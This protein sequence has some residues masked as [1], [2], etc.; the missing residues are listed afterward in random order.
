M[1]DILL[2]FAHKAGKY[3]LTQKSIAKTLGQKDCT[4]ESIVTE[5]DVTVSNMFA[6]FIK[7]NF[8]KL[9]Y[10][11]I[12]EEKISHLGHSVFDK[13]AQT[14]YQFVIDPIDG[15]VQFATG[16]ALYGITIG[17][18]KKGKPLI[19]L[20]YLPEIKELVYCDEKYAYS[21]Q[22]AFTSKAIK[23]RLKKQNKSDSS[24]I[25]GHTWLWHITDAFSI[26]KALVVDYYSAVSQSLY[27]LTGRAKAYCMFLHLWDIAGA[28]PI[29]QKIG[30]E[31]FE[32][33]SNQPY[34][35]ISSSYFTKDMWTQKPCILCYQKDLADIRKIIQPRNKN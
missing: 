20:I 6:T 32:Y 7:K 19:G 22:N 3:L 4:V 30:M 31:I 14:D 15:T 13:I 25:F 26:K 28:L 18:Y 10:I 17:V 12:D 9:N 5:A 34:D 35:K 1:I 11:I 23:T 27:T 24:I 21:V 33:D 8:S 2:R 29:A 16:H